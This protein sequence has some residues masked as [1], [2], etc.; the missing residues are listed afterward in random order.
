MNRIASMSLQHSHSACLIGLLTF[1]CSVVSAQSVPL[2]STT[3][4]VEVRV[5]D[6]AP[7]AELRTAMAT[8]PAVESELSAEPEWKPALK[9]G[10]ATSSLLAFQASGTAASRTARPI[11]GD[12]AGRSYQRYLKSFEYPIPEKFGASVKTQGLNNGGTP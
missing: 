2:T 1:S 5:P 9:V 8:P 12:L 11:T 10:E 7:A 4:V 6:P 3:P